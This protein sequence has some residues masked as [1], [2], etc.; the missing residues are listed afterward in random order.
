M[1]R[2][3]LSQ[4]GCFS[5]AIPLDLYRSLS[6]N[7]AFK[8]VTPLPPIPPRQRISYQLSH[9]ERHLENNKKQNTRTSDTADRKIQRERESCGL[10]TE[11]YYTVQ[12]V[13]ID[14][15]R[16]SPQP[17]ILRS[18][19]GRRGGGTNRDSGQRSV[20]PA[21]NWRSPGLEVGTE[22][23]TLCLSFQPYQWWG[24]QG[25]WCQKSWRGGLR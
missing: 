18:R 12:P 11:R 17:P 1:G 6:W 19:R 10:Y 13:Y 16:V 4:S 20:S 14:G 21:V 3:S 23:A 22:A 8:L 15:Q 2:N 24:C 7:I 9:S 5:T 25:F